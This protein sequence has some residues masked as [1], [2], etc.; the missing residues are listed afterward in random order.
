MSD[1]TAAGPAGPEQEPVAPQHAQRLMQLISGYWMTQT[2]RAVAE[3]SLADHAADGAATAA[4]MARREGADGEATFRLL[5]TATALGLF[6]DDGQG[7]FTPTPLGALLRRG[8]PGSLR[9]MAMVQG[10]PF[11]WQAWGVLPQAVRQGH[12]AVHAA[13]GLPPGQSAFAYFDEHTDEGAL[14]AAAMANVTGV[15][16]QDIVAA[17]DTTGVSLAVDVGGSTGALVLAM[18]QADP[19]LRGAVLELAHLTDEAERQARKA[20]VGDRFTAVQGDFFQEVPAADLYL[21]KT[22]LHDWD[23]AEC[24][25]ILRNCR[26]AALPGARMIVVELVVGKPGEPGIGALVDLNMLATTSGRER[27]LDEY[28]ALFEATGWRRT[29]LTRTRSP[30][31]VQ[32]LIAV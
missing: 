9:E 1:E 2:V 20:G 27:D 24:L 16:Q 22:V 7:R 15:V 25:T 11:H 23:D 8:V 4:E 26:K 3:L 32:E 10:A 17:V 6:T 19:A 21:L 29:S 28:D 31:V 14:F 12:S 30:Q 18:M 5:R 13:L